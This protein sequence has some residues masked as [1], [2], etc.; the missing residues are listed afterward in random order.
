MSVEPERVDIK[1]STVLSPGRPG[2]TQSSGWSLFMTS[3]YAASPS[4]GKNT[5]RLKQAIKK[6]KESMERSN[7][8]ERK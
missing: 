3:H 1:L 5:P 4:C 2:R 7:R 8:E 6:K